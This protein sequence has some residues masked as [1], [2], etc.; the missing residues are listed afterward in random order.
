MRLAAVH[1]AAFEPV[2]R[3]W[4]AEEIASFARAGALFADDQDRGF[5]LFTIAA[6]E[7][8][9]L[10]IAVDP[11]H[12]RRGLARGLLK[13][14]KDSL[15]EIG[16]TIIFLEVA[17]DNRAAIELYQSLAFTVKGTRRA[18][19]KRPGGQRV[20]AIMMALAL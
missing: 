3:G 7:A 20:D 2:S 8:E 17:S 19:Y 6:D 15:S 10:T 14:A 16:V 4:T 12:Q 13:A 9:L 1:R 11:D 18:Y 5:A